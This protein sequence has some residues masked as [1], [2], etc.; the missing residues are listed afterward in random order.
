MPAVSQSIL[1]ATCQHDECQL[2][3]HALIIRII[4]LISSRR[5]PPTHQPTAHQCDLC[6]VKCAVRVYIE[7]ILL[8]DYSYAHLKTKVIL[9][10]SLL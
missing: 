10:S 9:S 3:V 6:K 8:H 2:L 1:T 7:T 5:N 4:V